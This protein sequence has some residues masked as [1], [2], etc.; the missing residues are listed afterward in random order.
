M[1]KEWGQF[2]SGNKKA[3]VSIGGKAF[4]T[5]NVT[6]TVEP[7][8]KDTFLRWAYSIASPHMTYEEWKKDIEA[9]E[10]KKRKRF[11]D[12]RHEEYDEPMG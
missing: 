8:N 12:W 2:W 9:R 3:E 10:E 4:W 6:I 1:S 5:T 11:F 7:L